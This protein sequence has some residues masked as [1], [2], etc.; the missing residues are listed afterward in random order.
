MLILNRMSPE[1]LYQQLARHY[2]EQI[3]AG[4]IENG[5]HLPSI[6]KQ[7]QELDCSKN[8]VIRAYRQLLVDGYISVRRSKGHIVCCVPQ[9]VIAQIK[10]K[11]SQ[12]MKE[13]RQNGCSEED[14]QDII[15]IVEGTE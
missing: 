10:V 3:L 14:I 13:A 1:P 12:L 7:M 11:I 8:T 5:T 4:V 2:K 6:A 15:A 9:K